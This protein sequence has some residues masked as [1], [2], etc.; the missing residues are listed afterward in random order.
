VTRIRARMVVRVKK[1]TIATNASVLK[2]GWD[3]I[4]KIKII[5]TRIRARMVERV[6]KLTIATNAN[7]LKAG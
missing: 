6:K 7:V 1:L 3:T 2:V 5:V 4:V